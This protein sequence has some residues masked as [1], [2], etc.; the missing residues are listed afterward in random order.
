MPKTKE[1]TVELRAE[2]VVKFKAG[3]SAVELAELYQISRKT[4]YNLVKKKDTVGSLKNLKRTGRKPVLNQKQRRHIL[5]VVVNNPTAS[6]VKIAAES[7]NII[8]RQISEA[9]LRRRLK[10]ADINTYVV[11]KVID[12]TPTNQS[13]RLAFAL[14]YSKKP[15]DFWFNVLWTDEAAFQFQGS[16]SKHF[17]HLKKN[18]QYLATQPINR[19][20]GGS[21]M[22]WGCLSYYGFGDLVPIEG[23]LNQNGYLD[24]LNDH[25]FTSGNRLFPTYD[26][27]LQ[28]DNAP[29]H[30]GKLPTQL[31]KDLSQA[32]LPW[33]AQ[34]PDLNI[35][36]N[37]WAIV[38][39]KRTIDKY[40]KREGTIAEIKDIWSKLTIEFAQTLVR[41]IPDRL[42][43]VIDAKGG[44][45]KY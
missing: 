22:F 44:I 7:K 41:S 34:S 14:E 28:H 35:I 6:P 36:E 2:I 30:K 39:N 3:T 25:A 1:L 17:M 43:A 19:F 20:G 11:R 16:Y 26:W 27:I 37:V 40:R 33:P 12:I 10:E 24:I 15:L 23:T 4:V 32:V 8:G 21:V 38:K 13:K 5:N 31:L 29:C 45:T 9:T 42:Q 18:Q